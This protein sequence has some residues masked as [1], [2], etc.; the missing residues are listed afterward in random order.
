MHY[1]RSLALLIVAV[2]MLLSLVRAE[3]FEAWVVP[4]STIEA[5]A[6]NVLFNL[7]ANNTNSTVNITLVNITLP[8]GFVF[9]SGSNQT[10]AGEVLFYNDSLNL[11]WIN[12]TAEGFIANLSGE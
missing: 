4:N 7:T 1:R 10:S 3:D 5:G 9:I 2:V 6:G 11:T 8:E 12:Q